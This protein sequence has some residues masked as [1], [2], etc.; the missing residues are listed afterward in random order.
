MNHESSLSL[1][2]HGAFTLQFAADASQQASGASQQKASHAA[3][4]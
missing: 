1:L 2:H 3:E 4:L